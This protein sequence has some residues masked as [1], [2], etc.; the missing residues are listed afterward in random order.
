MNTGSINYNKMIYITIIA[1]V[2]IIAEYWSRTVIAVKGRHQNE[3]GK[4]NRQ[5]NAEH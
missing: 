3:T 4:S 1:V 2:W 5:N